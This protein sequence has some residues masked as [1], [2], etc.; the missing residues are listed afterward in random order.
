MAVTRLFGVLLDSR[1]RRR[2][3]TAE[4][5]EAARAAQAE[6]E[7]RHRPTALLVT[8]IRDGPGRYRYLV[9]DRAPD[10]HSAAVEGVL[11]PYAEGTAHDKR[12]ARHGGVAAARAV[13]AARGGRVAAEHDAVE[14]VV[15]WPAT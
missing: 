11:V 12:T 3:D 15:Q 4:T 13:I 2:L 1:E 6:A 7:A 14:V 10:Y 9:F 8:V 5:L